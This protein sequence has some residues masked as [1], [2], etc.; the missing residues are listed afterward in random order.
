MKRFLSCDWGTSSFRL[1]L[2]EEAGM[3]VLAEENSGRGIASTYANW[4]RLASADEQ[5]RLLFYLDVIREPIMAIESDMDISLKGVP[6]L[7]SGMASSSIGMANLPYQDIPFKLDGSA[8]GAKFFP[9]SEHFEHPVLL[10]SGLKSDG[11]VMRGEET[12]LIGMVADQQPV[13]GEQLYIFP[14]THSK[15]ILVSDRQLIGF[16]TY[17]TGEIFELL[18]QKSILSA[19][20]EKAGAG[21]SEAG[22]K[23]FQQGV[24]D[25]LGTNLLHAAFRVRINSLFGTLSK[26][27]NYNY[28]SGLLIGTELQELIPLAD[29]Q[30]YLCAGAHLKQWYEGGLQVLG[31]EDRLHTFS[32]KQVDRAVIRGQYEIYKH[33]RNR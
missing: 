16:K 18:S 25:A 30:I 26:Q 14:G 13:P 12:Q 19:G 17:M 5:Q 29:T 27:E 4:N 31:I 22:M 20:V 9:E 7:L 23:S 3:E 32:A 24:R 1:R 6:L 28:L 33:Y 15:H 8:A 11:D 21:V 10:I 2:V